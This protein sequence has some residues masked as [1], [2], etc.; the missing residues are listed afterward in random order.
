MLTTDT[1][2]TFSLDVGGVTKFNYN[3]AI[4]SSCLGGGLGGFGCTSAVVAGGGTD[5]NHTPQR[6][7][8]TFMISPAAAH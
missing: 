7:T 8:P 1:T 3:L 2:T 6:A 4:N 5:T